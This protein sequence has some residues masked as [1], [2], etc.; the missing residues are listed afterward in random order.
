MQV[1][2][3]LLT[4]SLESFIIL[5]IFSA[6]MWF[7]PYMLGIPYLQPSYP[8]QVFG[9]FTWF[10][11]SAG[12]AHFIQFFCQI[13]IGFV[14]MRW[15]ERW[16]LIPLRSAVPFTIGLFIM[17]IIAEIQ[18]F[19]SRMVALL[20][21]LLATRDLLSMYSYNGEKVSAAFNIGFFMTCAAFF[22]QKYLY[23]LIVFVFGMVL[24]STF[25]WR[26]FFALLSG[27]L[28]PLFLACGIF[29]LS[30]NLD[31]LTVIVSQSHVYSFEQSIPLFS[32]DVLFSGMILLLF[33]ISLVSYF[34][35]SLNFK[36][37][38]RLN[39]FFINL[40]F[41]LTSI[42]T[43]LF[44]QSVDKL[45]FVPILFFILL[46]SFFFSTNQSK[47]ANI[48]FIIFIVCGL[49]YRVFNLIGF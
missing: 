30:D 6:I 33:L 2:K 49:A 5:I 48:A 44:F 4:P 7:L 3:K 13:A 42:W 26:T 16:Q 37:H 35:V 19:D 29:Y 23:L 20:L 24:F 25:S 39:F 21:F 43:S 28:V 1:L 17:S 40:A 45:L 12:W 14:L 36:L 47:F 10:T 34:S 41:V 9:T 8:F 38:V 32:S 18:F 22:E 31:F 15:C 11:L 46:L 27:I